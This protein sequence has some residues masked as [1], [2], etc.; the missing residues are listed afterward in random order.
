[1]N[2]AVHLRLF[3]WDFSICSNTCINN[4]NPKE[5]MRCFRLR[6]H[7]IKVVKIWR[8]IPLLIV[9]PNG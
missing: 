4:S 8:R 5:M 3:D 2:D 7:S 9:V 1:M 6:Q